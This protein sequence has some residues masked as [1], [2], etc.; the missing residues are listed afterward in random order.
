LTLFSGLNSA[1]KQMIRKF[2]LHL[3][4]FWVTQITFRPVGVSLS[5]SGVRGHP[6]HI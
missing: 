2:D 1:K 3:L 4:Q 5:H 6:E